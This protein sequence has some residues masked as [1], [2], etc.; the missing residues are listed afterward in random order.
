MNKISIY[1][2]I[3]AFVLVGI[4]WF[5]F[6]KNN[7]ANSLVLN[8]KGEIITNES[9]NKKDNNNQPAPTQEKIMKATL[10]TNKGDITIEFNTENAPNTVANFIKLAKEGF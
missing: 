7:S 10:H 6:N 1:A 9:I 5:L 4:G 8:E 3:F 2:T